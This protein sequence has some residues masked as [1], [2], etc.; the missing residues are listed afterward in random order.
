MLSAED[1]ARVFEN[2]R[3]SLKPH[4]PFVFDVNLEGAYT[5]GWKSTCASV[6]AEHACFIRGKYDNATRLARTFIT[7]FRDM[8]EWRRTDFTLTQRY[9]PAEQILELLRGAGFTDPRCYNAERD[10]GISGP[11][12]EGRGVIVARAGVRA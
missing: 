2:V 12:G 1:L 11:F 8:G 7:I 5:V 10:L 6:D 9:Y 4:A 3:H